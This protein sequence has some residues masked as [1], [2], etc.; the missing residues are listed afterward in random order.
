MSV[1]YVHRLLL[2]QIANAFAFTFFRIL[3]VSYL[4]GETA[5]RLLRRM[6]RGYGCDAFRVIQSVRLNRSKFE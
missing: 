1:V 5:W 3:S 4:F 6:V 2:R